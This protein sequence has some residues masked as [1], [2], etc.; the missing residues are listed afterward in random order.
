MRSA[1]FYTDPVTLIK[2]DETTVKGIKAIVQCVYRIIPAVL[3]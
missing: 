3:L 1:R 2:Q